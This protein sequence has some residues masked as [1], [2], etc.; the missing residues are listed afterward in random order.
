MKIFRIL[1]SGVTLAFLLVMTT[2]NA[3]AQS[4]DPASAKKGGMD[5][6]RLAQIKVRMQGFVDKGQ[7]AGAV[8]LVAR[9]GTIVQFEAVGYQEMEQRKPMRTDSIFQIMSMTKPITGLGIMMLVEEGKLS[10]NDPVERVLP[11]FKGQW[12]VAGKETREGKEF[13]ILQHPSR[14]III[15]DL[16][17]HTSGVPDYPPA[18][19]GI[20]Q[21]MHFPLSE[22]A[23]ICSQQPLEFEPG[24]RWKYSNPGI[25]ILGRLIEVASGEKYEKFMHDRLF[26]PLGM[27]D[28]FIFPPQEK[29]PRIAMVYQLKEGKLEKASSATLA[30]DPW[31]FR[32]GARYPAPD[33]G[34][35]STASDLAA[36]YQMLLNHGVGGGKRYLSPAGLAVMTSVHTGDIKAGWTPGDGYGLTWEV[37]REPLGTLRLNSIGTFGHGGAF[38]TEGWIDPTKDMFTILLIQRSEGGSLDERNA[39]QNM[40]AAAIVE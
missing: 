6:E 32:K 18:L 21:K 15:R 9:H 12:M 17:T 24:S 27:K 10:L 5:A 16:M 22:V 26:S 29:I 39:L 25:A 7:I 36:L 13:L 20:Y 3:A 11:E 38:G 31:L 35:Y 30:G 28:T 33:F 2:L 1:T 40:A 23:A 34:L 8:T 14:P 19:E 4:A 37:T